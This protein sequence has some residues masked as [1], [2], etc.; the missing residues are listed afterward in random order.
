MIK[1]KIS[2]WWKGRWLLMINVKLIINIQEA[3]VWWTGRSEE[4]KLKESP[5]VCVTRFKRFETSKHN[6]S[7][8]SLPNHLIKLMGLLLNIARKRRMIKNELSEQFPWNCRWNNAK[9]L[10]AKVLPA[11]KG[12]SCWWNSKY[13]ISNSLWIRL[14]FMPGF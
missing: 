14:N 12:N 8:Q 11:D 4:V 9:Q 13:P 6:E 5:E 7:V 10:I 2:W 1:R 3:G